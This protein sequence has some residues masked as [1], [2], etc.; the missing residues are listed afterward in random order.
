MH[1]DDGGAVRAL[2]GGCP[3]RRDRDRHHVHHPIH[4]LS[5]PANSAVVTAGQITGLQWQV[6]SSNGTGTCTVELHIDNVRFVT[7]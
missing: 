7:Q 3:R 2:P 4:G 5:N 1:R 6:S